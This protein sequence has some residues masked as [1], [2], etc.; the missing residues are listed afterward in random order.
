MENRPQSIVVPELSNSDFFHGRFAWLTIQS[1]A[2]LLATAE[3]IGV[4]DLSKVRHMR[5]YQVA[6]VAAIAED[7]HRRGLQVSY[8]P[9]DDSDAREHL[10]RLGLPEIVLGKCGGSLKQRSTNLPIQV[11]K[12]RAEVGFGTETTEILIGELGCDLPAGLKPDI[13]VG[14]DE[15]VLNAATHAESAIGCVVVGQAFPKTGVLEVAV[16]DLGVTIRGHLS[17]NP[18][19]QDLSDDASA[20]KKALEEGVTGTVGRNRFSEPNSGAGFFNLSDFLTAT[21]G[22]LSILSGSAIVCN[23]KGRQK[24]HQLKFPPFRGTLVN[25]SFATR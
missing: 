1:A 8:R 18:K 4:I 3:P 9:P 13:A 5:P 12:S 15:M 11:L 2:N 19:H 24:V 6:I 7:Q 25:I 10:D 22:S 14:I 16:L 20:I 21:G 23:L 17:K